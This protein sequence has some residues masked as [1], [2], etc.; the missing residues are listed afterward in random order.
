[1]MFEIIITQPIL[2]GQ[3]ITQQFELFPPT[4]RQ[5]DYDLARASDNETPYD[6]YVYRDSSKDLIRLLR[7][8]CYTSWEWF[9]L[10][11]EAERL[12]CAAGP[13]GL[14]CLEH[15]RNRWL[16]KGV[17]PYQYQIDTAIKVIEQLHGRA[18]LADEVGLG[19]TI[20]AGLVMKEYLLRNMVGRVLILT[21]ASLCRQWQ[22]ELRDKFGLD[23]FIPRCEDDWERWDLVVASID[24]AKHPVN[25]VRILAQNYDLV[26]VDEAHK[27]KNT[28]TQNWQLVNRIRTKYLLMLTATPV[29][30]DLKELYNLITLLKPGQLL[31]KRQHYWCYLDK[32]EKLR[33]G[34]QNIRLA[35]F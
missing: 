5:A 11:M 12:A 22:W 33:T 13:R 7:R 19:K 27:L 6:V 17:I 25:M 28:R 21:P 4:I 1:M 29:Q 16:E 8:R 30:N 14:I 31:A 20:E 23:V 10:G 9:K 2:K 24:T 3:Q 34:E 18:I 15:L 26:I 32:P 35:D